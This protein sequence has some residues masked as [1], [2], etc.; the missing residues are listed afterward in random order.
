[1]E[2]EGRPVKF[3]YYV[4][5]EGWREGEGIFIKWGSAADDH[6]GKPMQITF[7]VVEDK[8]TGQVYRID[9]HNL[10]FTDRSVS[11]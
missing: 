7:A 10:Q 3:K 1:M 8:K 2:Y 11:F 9:E 6:L 5:I 4:T